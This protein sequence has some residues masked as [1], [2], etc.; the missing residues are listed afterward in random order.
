MGSIDSVDVKAMN[1]LTTAEE[2]VY[3]YLQFNSGASAAI[4]ISS[5]TYRGSGHF[6][7]FTGTQGTA[8]LKNQYSTTLTNFELDV[9]YKS[10]KTF[11]KKSDMKVDKLTD[12]RVPAVS[13]LVKKFGD[14]I[15]TG[16][17]Q[18]PNISDA[19]RVQKLLN[20]STQSIL[21]KKLVQLD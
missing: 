15:D 1:Y 16:E 18:T 19:I 14:W 4:C 20:A 21:E 6:L 12:D 13:S 10:G 8:R 5:N 9:F 11:K 7:E 3:I 17:I 2:V